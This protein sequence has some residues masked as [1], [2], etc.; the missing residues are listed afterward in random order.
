MIEDWNRI[1]A[2]EF[3]STFAR[4]WRDQN[5]DW[6][7]KFTDWDSE[8]DLKVESLKDAIHTAEKMFLEHKY[9]EPKIKKKKRPAKEKAIKNEP[10]EPKKQRPRKTTKKKRKRNVNSAKKSR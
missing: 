6:L 3:E 7:C 1:T 4:V 5:A 10:A 8:F 2:L 9:S